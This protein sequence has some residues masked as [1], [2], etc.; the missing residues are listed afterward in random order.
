MKLVIAEK[1]LPANLTTKFNEKQIKIIVLWES[2][3]M[4]ERK[5]K[6]F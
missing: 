5:L 2:L 4:M 1:T 6:M 3:I